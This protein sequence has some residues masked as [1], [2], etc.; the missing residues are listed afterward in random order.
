LRLGSIGAQIGESINEFSADT[1]LSANSNSKV[2]TQKAVKTYIDKKT[3]TKGFT[4][5]AGGA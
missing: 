2:A 4:F 1:T 3:K 5:W